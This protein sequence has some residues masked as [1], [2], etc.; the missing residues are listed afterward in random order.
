MSMG[1]PT[2]NDVA[3]IA[4]V[5]KKTVSRVINNSPL[6]GEDTREKVAK[7]IAELDYVPNPQA[8]ALALRRNFLI[9]LLHDGSDAMSLISA[10]E[11]VLDAVAGSD[12]ALVVHRLGGPQADIPPENLLRGFLERHR[13]AGAIMLNPLYEDPAL[14]AA[15]RD[16]G[17]PAL[18][19]C[20]GPLADARD[21]LTTRD[22][23]AVAQA[24]REL[25]GLG[26]HRIGLLAGPDSSHCSRER[27]L[28]YIDAM[29]ELGL[30]RGPTLIAGGGFDFASGL[31]GAELLLA[32]SPRPT[33]IIALG[34]QLTSSLLNA[35]LRRGLHVPQALSV[36]GFLSDDQAE[37]CWPPL[38]NIEVP[39]R[40]MARTAA[41]QLAGL[42]MASAPPTEFAASITLR[43]STAAPPP[44]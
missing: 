16:Y 2:I 15:C 27:E 34:A 32:V 39:Y 22:R 1:R 30:D 38:S 18:Q 23:E 4:G 7:V 24:V 44:A 29:A 43:G 12:Y 26:H 41:L 5:S 6:L 28:G 14:I 8:R 40:A 13:P 3:R 31:A 25:H 36:I 10:H 20:N 37:K 35:A 42:G 17:T 11:G 33:A 21:C 9:A 19:V